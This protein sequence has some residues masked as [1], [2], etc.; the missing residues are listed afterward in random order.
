MKWIKASERLPENDH[1]RPI[2]AFG[3]YYLSWYDKSSNKWLTD[4]DNSFQNEEV[5]WLD[6][7]ESPSQGVQEAAEV[8]GGF[9]VRILAESNNKKYVADC[10]RCGW[11]GSSALLNISKGHPESGCSGDVH[12]PICDNPEIEEND[13]LIPLPD[14][15]ERL[16][17]GH[18]MLREFK[19]KYE[20]VE[21]EKYISGYLEEQLKEA[22]KEIDSLR[23]QQT[24]TLL[25]RE[26]FDKIWKN[27]YV[28]GITDEHP[29]KVGFSS[30]EQDMETFA[31]QFNL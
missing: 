5:E 2:K 27:G 8:I 25:T 14:Y 26:V 21:T 28:S 29:G 4:H 3:S 30:R 31:K 22:Q 19:D 18:K 9:Y 13:K 16:A 11:I 6:E 20:G 23:S 12:C 24:G 7:S 1:D 10:D 17:K 15:I